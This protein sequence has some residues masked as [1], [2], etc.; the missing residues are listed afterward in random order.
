M[1]PP[2][3]QQIM[4]TGYPNFMT[5]TIHSTCVCGEAVYHN[6]GYLFEDKHFCCA[7]CT[8]DYLLKIGAITDAS[9]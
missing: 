4:Q 7:S 8:V 3:I 5:S 6:E 1:E 9:A 2:M